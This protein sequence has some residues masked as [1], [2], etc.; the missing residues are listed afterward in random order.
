MEKEKEWWI[1]GWKDKVM[2]GQMEELR[3][4][5][6]FKSVLYWPKHSV[7]LWSLDCAGPTQHL[8]V[9]TC[10]RLLARTKS[11]ITYPFLSALSL[12]LSFSLSLSLSLPTSGA[13]LVDNSAESLAHRESQVW[14]FVDGH[15]EHAGDAFEGHQQVHGTRA[16]AREHGPNLKEKHKT[17][18]SQWRSPELLTLNIFKLSQCRATWSCNVW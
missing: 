9:S 18:T 16:E 15:T 2:D 13:A 12:L 4:S 3:L 14:P 6:I 10:T 8:F 17:C 1:D 7:L 11:F 5:S